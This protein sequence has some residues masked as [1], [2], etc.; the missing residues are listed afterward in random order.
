[1]KDTFDFKDEKEIYSII[2][3][4]IKYYRKLYSLNV[5]ELTQ[6]HLAELANVSTSLIGNLESKKTYQGISIYNLYKISL[7]LNV[8]IENFFINR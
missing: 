5:E 4:N 8:P 6:E 2:G 7:I 3:K 1:M